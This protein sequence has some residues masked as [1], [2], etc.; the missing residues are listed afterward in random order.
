MGD[1]DEMMPIIQSFMNDIMNIS[2]EEVIEE[3]GEINEEAFAYFNAV[4]ANFQS[5]EST[6][7]IYQK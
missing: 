7:N 5:L 6:N 2:R 4:K 3:N 1:S